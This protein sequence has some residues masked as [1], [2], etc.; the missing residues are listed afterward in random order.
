MLV[1][2]AKVDKK[3]I[4]MIL[5]GVVGAIILLIAL[6]G[7]NKETA[8][9]ASVANNDDRVQFL[10]SYGWEV[11]TSPVESC[12]V[13]IPAEH[14]EVFDRY[15]SLQKSMGYDL[16]D[17]AGTTVMRYVYQVNNYPGAT[18]PV[19]ATLLIS[20]NQVIG[21]DVTD[22][23]AKGAIRSFSMPKAA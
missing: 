7:G 19:Y 8:A 10:S 12:Q 3:K 20:K 15:N 18:E 13:R 4:L 1:M 22:T 17:Y 5:A 21:G 9:T 2:T 23:A 14:S 11:T 16:T 6:L